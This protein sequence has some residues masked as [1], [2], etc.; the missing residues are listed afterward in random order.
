[1]AA[2]V[3]GNDAVSALKMGRKV[4][5]GMGDAG[6]AMQQYQWL[7]RGAIPFKI[8]DGKTVDG[9]N[10]RAGPSNGVRKRV[11]HFSF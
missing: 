5:E 2:H 7:S 3:D 10:V 9:D 4:I 6:D 11:G 1:M 8:V